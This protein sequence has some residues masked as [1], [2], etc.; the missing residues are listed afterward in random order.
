MLKS[1]VLRGAVVKWLTQLFA[2]QPFVGSNPIRASIFITSKRRSMGSQETRSGSLE[3]YK[4]FNKLTLTGALGLAV[5]AAVTP[6]LQSLVTPALTFAAFDIGQIVFI[7]KV[8]KK[9]AK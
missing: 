5:I 7:D 9:K 3:K 6:G 4:D 8:N 1:I 2:E